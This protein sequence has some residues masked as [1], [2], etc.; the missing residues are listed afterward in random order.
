MKPGKI[1]AGTEFPVMMVP[2][3]PEGGQAEIG[4]P[5]GDETPRK[6]K[7]YRDNRIC[8]ARVS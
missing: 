4:I 1:E 7:D 2:D 8:R 6:P 5:R 3:P